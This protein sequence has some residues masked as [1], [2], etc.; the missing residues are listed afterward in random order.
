[1]ISVPL[2]V[3][4]NLHVN[5]IRINPAK[6]DPQLVV[7]PNA[8]LPQP[9]AGE[10]LKVISGNRTEIRECHRGMNLVQFAFSHA[11]NTLEPSAEL[12]PKYLLGLSVQEGPN[13]KTRLLPFCI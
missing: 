1:M 9:I 4:D 7:D 11:S 8:V 10:G 12:P 13:H 3:V 2:V 5:S 6:A